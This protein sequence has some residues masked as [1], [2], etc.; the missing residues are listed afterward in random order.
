MKFL[1]VNRMKE[2]KEA[3]KLKSEY[4]QQTV[5]LGDT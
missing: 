3:P 4:R 1:G 5:P 2:T